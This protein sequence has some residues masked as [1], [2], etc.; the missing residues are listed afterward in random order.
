MGP[1]GADEV[2]LILPCTNYKS[3]LPGLPVPSARTGAGPE[4]DS[5]RAGRSKYARQI[6]Q[7]TDSI[8]WHVCRR[9]KMQATALETPEFFFFCDKC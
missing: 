7:D 8:C 1:H 3:T 4:P 5:S 6:F 9:L 2:D